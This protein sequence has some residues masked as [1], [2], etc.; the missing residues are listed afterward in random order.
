MDSTAGR[1]LSQWDYTCTCSKTSR[2]HYNHNRKGVC[3]VMPTRRTRPTTRGWIG[4]ICCGPIGSIRQ[5]IDVSFVIVYMV[6]VLGEKVFK[7]NYPVTESYLGGR[8]ITF[9]PS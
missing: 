5:A 1:K 8:C 4:R 7:H 3:H 2:L 6:V 9:I